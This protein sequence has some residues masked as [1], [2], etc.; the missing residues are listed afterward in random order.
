MQKTGES[1]TA[2][3]SR[4]MAKSSPRNVVPVSRFAEVAGMSDEAVETKTGKTWAAW[5]RTL[6]AVGMAARPHREIAKHVHEAHEG[7]SRWWAQS[8]TVAY[9]RIKG[10]RDVGQRRGGGYDANKS[11]TYAVPVAA[12]YRAWSEKRRRTRWLPEE[13]TICTSTKEKSMRITWPDGTRASIYFTAKD[14]SKSTVS[15]QHG[16]L[17]TRR[18]VDRVKSLWSARLDALRDVLG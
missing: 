18:D 16:D 11:R 12:L 8:V 2:A 9:E 13:I 15:V 14:A 7:V 6:D 1:Y 17:A 4:I 5:V 10:L 3:R